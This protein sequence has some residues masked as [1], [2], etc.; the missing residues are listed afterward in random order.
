MCIASRRARSVYLHLAAVGT[1]RCPLLTAEHDQIFTF[2]AKMF[3]RDYSSVELV[4]FWG[5]GAG[6]NRGG[7]TP[8]ILG[9]PR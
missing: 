5:S 9:Y 8:C 7:G 1:C 2:V 6:Q 3:C 4:E